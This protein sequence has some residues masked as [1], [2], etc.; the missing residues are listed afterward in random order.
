[1]KNRWLSSVFHVCLL[2][3]RLHKDDLRRS[4]HV[5]I[6][7]DCTWKCIRVF[8]CL[9]V[10]RCYLLKKSLSL[11][12]SSHLRCHPQSSHRTFLKLA[13]KKNHLDAQLILSN[14]VNLYMFRAYLDPSSGGT[15]LCIQQ[16]GL[17][18]LFRWL[19]CSNPTRTTDSHLKRI[20]STNCCTH[21]VAPP[22][23]GPR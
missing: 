12:P 3:V 16:L 10:C 7:V 23:D 17:I 21:T 19:S 6:L 22:D 18:I 8:Q 2:D 5:G 4:I 14:F 20:I 1:M 13:V 11:T 9:Y 15:T